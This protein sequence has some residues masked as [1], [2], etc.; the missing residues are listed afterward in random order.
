MSEGR[1]AGAARRVGSGTNRLVRAWKALPGESRLAAYASVGLFV[2][3][4]L[5]WYQVTLIATAKTSKLQSASASITGW[6]A[7][8]FVEAAVLIVAAGVL[9]LLFQRAEGRAFHLPGGDGGV[10]TAAGLWTCVLIVWRIFD[11]QGATT[12]GPSATTSGI[13]WGIFFALAA[14]AFL[15]YSGSRIRAAHRPEPP[16]P[17]EH[18]PPT[19]SNAAATTVMYERAP[20]PAPVAAS[21]GPGSAPPRSRNSAPPRSRTS[22][23]PRSESPAPPRSRTPAPPR[24][25]S[26]TY[27][28]VASDAPAPPKPAP[29]PADTAP[30]ETAPDRPRRRPSAADMFER[31]VPDDPPSMPFG[32]AKPADVDPTPQMRSAKPSDEAAGERPDEQLTIPLGSDD[33]TRRLGRDDDTLRLDRDDDTLRLDRDDETL[34]LDR[35]DETL[36]LDRD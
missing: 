26:R 16:L 18:S 34:R 32:R 5:P 21:P 6:G 13:E 3:L 28:A 4:F 15:A 12:N 33:D 22:A 20:A 25:R 10:I 7:F 11:K 2:T 14:A 29:A 24:R 35:D 30:A 31:V 1:S 36:R 9:V 8:S 27:E 23:P 17:G 19:G